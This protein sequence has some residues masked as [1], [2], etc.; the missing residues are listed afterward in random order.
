MSRGQQTFKLGVNTALAH[1]ATLQPGDRLGSEAALAELLQTSRTTVRAVLK[2]LVDIGLIEWLGR[3]KIL[4]RLPDPVDF[5][6]KPEATLPADLAE[7]R[8]LEWVMRS[9]L[10]PG[11]VL[12]EV[13]VARILSVPVPQVRELLIRFEPNGLIEKNTHKNWVLNGFTAQFATELADMRALIEGEAF[14]RLLASQD[15]GVMRQMAEMERLHIALLARE[16][17]AM[18]EFPALDAAFH[19]VIFAA[20][21]NRFF[22]EFA[23]R[24]SLIV[25]Y[26]YQWN[27]CDEQVRNRVALR[28]HLQII[29]ACLVGD[30][31]LARQ[32]F[33]AHLETA[34]RTL[35]A[36][37]STR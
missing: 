6:P 1:L 21:Q 32:A 8:F 24:I 34:R 33:V 4:R 3:D 12:R 13:E 9:D 37:I 26:H 2:H 5:F 30:K 16:D 23:Q 27:K 19:R 18:S 20:A 25:H 36:S 14:A 22:D 15:A 11:T 28:E 29:R 35:V 10:A 31:A 7:E 17:D